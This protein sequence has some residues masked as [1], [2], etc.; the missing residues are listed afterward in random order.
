MHASKTNKNKRKMHFL[1]L[2]DSNM[3]FK[4]EYDIPSNL[5]KII[6]DFDLRGLLI[7][8]YK[9]GRCEISVNFSSKWEG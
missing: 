9:Y 6:Y 4:Y 7:V 2:D 1:G 5:V 8:S 3:D